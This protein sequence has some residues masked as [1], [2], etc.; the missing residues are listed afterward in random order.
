MEQTMDFNATN[1]FYGPTEAEAVHK[2]RS[3]V[4]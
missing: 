3:F 2:T 1:T 4:C